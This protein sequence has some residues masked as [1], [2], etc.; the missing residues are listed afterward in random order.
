MDNWTN[1]LTANPIKLLLSSNDDILTHFVE[2]DLLGKT[3]KMTIYNKEIDQIIKKQ[4]PNGS[5]FLRSS[6]VKKYPSINHDLV[7]TFKSM[8]LLV[9]KY[10]MD[11]SYEIENK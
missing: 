8:R 7:E 10:E 11:K 5:W 1:I 9:V 4:Q 2:R 6:S 3:N